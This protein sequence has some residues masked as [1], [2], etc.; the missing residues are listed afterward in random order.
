MAIFLLVLVVLL[1]KTLHGF[2]DVNTIFH[3]LQDHM[4]AIQ[5]LSLGSADEKLGT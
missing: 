4:S 3:L 2:Q 1:D 5:P